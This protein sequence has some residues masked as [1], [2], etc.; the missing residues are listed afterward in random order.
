MQILLHTSATKQE[1]GSFTSTTIPRSGEFINLDGCLFQAITVCYE[2][3][4]E[5][6]NHAIIEVAPANDAARQRI[7][8]A[9]FKTS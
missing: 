8:E 2:I 9:L 5:N 7:S 4:R 6:S 3:A 1:V